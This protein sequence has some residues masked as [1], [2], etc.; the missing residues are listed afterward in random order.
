MTIKLSAPQL[1]ELAEDSLAM[2]LN[3]A[4]YLPNMPRTDF[5]YDMFCAYMNLYLDEVEK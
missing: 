4:Q 3:R 5:Y 1:I 2:Y